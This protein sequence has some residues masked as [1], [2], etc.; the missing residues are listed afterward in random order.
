MLV[1][2]EHPTFSGVQTNNQ[3][4]QTSTGLSHCESG[5]WDDLPND[6]KSVH[7]NGTHSSMC[8]LVHSLGFE[9]FFFLSLP[10]WRLFSWCQLYGHLEWV[11]NF[12]PSAM[13][14]KGKDEQEATQGCRQGSGMTRCIWGTKAHEE[15]RTLVLIHYNWAKGKD[16][17]ERVGQ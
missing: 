17:D 10:Y 14:H 3:W 12:L 9:R 7:I 4:I 15:P 5:H 11:P 6:T 16:K 2:L 1:I 8:Y 13:V